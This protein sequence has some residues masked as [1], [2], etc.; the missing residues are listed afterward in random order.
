MKISGRRHSGGFTLLELMVAFGVAALLVALSI[1]AVG[2]LYQSMQ[3][4]QAVGEIKGALESARYQALMSGAAV[5][6]LVQPESRELRVADGRIKHLP[7]RVSVSLMSA[8]QLQPDADTGVI[9]F[10]PD[11]SSSGGSISLMRD[12][13]AGVRLDVGWLLGKVSQSVLPEK[14]L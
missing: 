12:E 14:A 5:D 4:R 6:V 13:V 7:E 2:K 11:G 10:Y 8:A 3:Y 9:R 1:P